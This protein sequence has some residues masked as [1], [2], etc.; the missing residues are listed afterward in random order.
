M[1]TAASSGFVFRS[2]GNEGFAIPIARALGIAKQISAGR[3]SA[4]VHIGQTALLGVRVESPDGFGSAQGV[5]VTGVVPGSPAEDAGL[6]PND[7]ITLVDG[8]A[9]TSPQALTAL[10]LRHAPRDTVRVNWTDS[11]GERQTARV[12]LDSGPPQ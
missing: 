6:E 8:H 1:D 10:I 2:G 3:A 9:I 4:S 11:F 5:L 12:A 7:L